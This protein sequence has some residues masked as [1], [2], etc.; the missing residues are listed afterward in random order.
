MEGRWNRTAEEGWRRLKNEG[1][2]EREAM[3]EEI[4]RVV[5]ERGGEREKTHN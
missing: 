1:R 4:E 5:I 2:K 3:R